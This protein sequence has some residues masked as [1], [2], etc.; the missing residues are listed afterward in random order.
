MGPTANAHTWS[1]SEKQSLDGAQA[2]QCRAPSR[3]PLAPTKFP[4]VGAGSTLL[5]KHTAQLDPH[6]QIFKFTA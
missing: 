2:A 5:E 1:L 4:A 3:Y 6:H